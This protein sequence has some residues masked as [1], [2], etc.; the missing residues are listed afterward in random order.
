VAKQ[1]IEVSEDQALYFRARRGHL[2]GPGAPDPV[3]AAAAIVG[4]QSQ[5]VPPSL[6]ALSQRTEGRPDADSL[7]DLVFAERRLVRT[8]GQRDTVH[9]YAPGDWP[10]VV[11]ARAEWAPG[12][13]GGPPP[14]EK[15]V[16]RALARMRAR[17]RP[18]TRS[19]VEELVPASYEKAIAE[20]AGLAGM[21]VRRFAAARLLWQLNNRGDACIADKLG[22]EQAYAARE[23]WFAELE[24]PAIP[25][26]EAA[27]TLTRRYLAANAPATAQ[28]VAHFFNAR[29]GTAREWLAALAAGGE[30]VGVRCGGR[31]GLVALAADADELRRKPPGGVGDWPVRL[32]PLWDTLLM[33]HADKSWTVPAEPERP[34]VWRK[35]AMVSAVVLA[36]GRVVATW[37][38]KVRSRRVEV[39]VSPLSAWTKRH[40]PGVRRDAAAVA[41][42]FGAPEAVVTVAT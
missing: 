33:S 18:L 6:L 31:D 2:A 19:D 5:Q 28:D 13:R 21:E 36:R 20:R 16:D 12:G 9:L 39:T 41:S 24:W 10:H 22:A 26:R 40:E 23:H 17:R 29:V 15:A 3:A 38:H 4:A 35:A 11:A 7:R 37:S 27:V 32:L 25:P 8:W 30:L 34:E 1:A 14:P 42:H